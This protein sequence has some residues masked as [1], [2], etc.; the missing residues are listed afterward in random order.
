MELNDRLVSPDVVLEKIEPGMKI[1]LAT[2]SSEPRTL[3]RHLLSSDLPN[4]QDLE[5]LQIVSLGDLITVRDL[6]SHKFRLKTFFSGWVASDAI[7]GGLVDLIPCRFSRIP[8]LIDSGLLPVDAAFIQVTPPNEA[9][10]VSLGVSVDVARQVMDKARLVVGEVNDRVPYTYGDTFFHVD[11]FDCLVASEDDPLYL[12]RWP[13]DEIFDQVASNIA[14]VIEDGSCISFS[15]GPIYE[16]LGRH[17]STKHNL[18]VHS[19]FFTDAVMDLIRSGAVTN[20]NKGI[21]KGKSLASYAFGTRELF[22]WLD[23]NPQLEFQGIDLVFNPVQIGRNPKFIATIPARKV[24]ISGR[25]ALHIGK[26]A[27]ATT[28]GEAMDFI[29]GAELSRGGCTIFALPSRNLRGQPNI[30]VSVEE[31]PNLLGLRESVDMVV[32]EYGV[33]N[34]KGRTVRERAQALI[35]IAHPEDR[36]PLVEDAKRH[37]ILYQDQIYMTQCTFLLPADISARK[38]FKGNVEVR[39]RHIKPSDEEEMRR[40]FYRF[41]DRSVYYRYFSPIKTMPHAKMQQ[42]VNVD[43]NRICSIVALVGPPDSE[44]IVAEARFVKDRTRPY[45]DV[46]FVVD[47]DYQGIGIASY[48]LE[49]LTRIA[50]KRGLQGFVA[51]VL[52]SYK[53]MLKVF[54]KSGLPVKANLTSG[55]YEVTM[56]FFEEA[57]TR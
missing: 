13:V 56:P 28:P 52:A 16:A 9:G 32:T 50:K 47:E 57:S 21:Y 18:G 35:D 11:E 31:F 53:S 5:L 45:G 38:R 2:G 4:L 46:A 40:L 20:R 23:K 1:F 49:M 17:L 41:S 48:M 8:S 51:D 24:D 7:T 29:N 34:L 15:I 39:F 22:A 33:A 10:F 44:H 19:P 25:I 14:S 37:N 6:Q 3:V 26:G 54:E 12:Q 27:V 43:C 55:A 30:L 36:I 42:Y